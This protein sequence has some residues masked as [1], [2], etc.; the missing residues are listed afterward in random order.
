MF[1]ELKKLVFKTKLEP[2]DDNKTEQ[3]SLEDVKEPD[4]ST[5]QYDNS[6]QRQTEELGLIHDMP[7]FIS[8]FSSYTENLFKKIK[9]KNYYC[10]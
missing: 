10:S 8:I 3:E 1:E 7:F 4:A 9:N 5:T 2:E 6:E